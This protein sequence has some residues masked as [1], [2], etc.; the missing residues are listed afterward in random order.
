M[1][2]LTTLKR[3]KKNGQNHLMAWPPPIGQFF[4]F[5]FFLGLVRK[6]DNKIIF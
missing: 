1:S 3:I 6:I 4:F 5:F 2:D